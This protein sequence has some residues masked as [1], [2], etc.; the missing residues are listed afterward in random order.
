MD[1]APIREKGFD[2]LMILPFFLQPLLH[3]KRSAGN[4]ER[5]RY[6][7][8]LPEGAPP[9]LLLPQKA[10]DKAAFHLLPFQAVGN[11]LG[12]CLPKQMNHLG[13]GDETLEVVA[14][15]GLFALAA[16]Q[17]Q[18]PFQGLGQQWID[19]LMGRDDIFINVDHD[20]LIEG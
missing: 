12:G 9:F 8:N 5:D 10:F 17:T 7:G 1:S 16:C 14:N 11:G 3:E 15:D 2:S 13:T 6:N 19:L 4:P 18:D 20:D